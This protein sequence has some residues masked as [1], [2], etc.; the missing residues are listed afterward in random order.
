MHR[1]VEM[2]GGASEVITHPAAIAQIAEAEAVIE[3]ARE[4]RRGR[5]LGRGFS[6][7]ASTLQS[8][9]KP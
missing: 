3:T 6:D 4:R 8:V 9:E 7:V 2:L 5:G 1:G